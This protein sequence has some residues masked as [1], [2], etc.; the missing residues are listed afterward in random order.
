MKALR[1]HG[2]EDLRLEEVEPPTEELGADEVLLEGTACGIC[3]T[4]MHEYKHGPMM[5]SAEPHPLSGGSLPQI[6]GHEVAG[7][8]IGVGSD[9]GEV[10]IGDR[11][12]VM[13]MTYCG[14]CSHCRVG[15]HQL[16]R[17]LSTFGYRS[18][19]GGFAER[20][21][22]RRDQVALLP[23]GVADAA[24]ALVE[25]AA[26]AVTAAASAEIGEGDVVL[27]TGGGPIGQLS[28]LAAVTRGAATVLVSRQRPSRPGIDQ[29]EGITLTDK[30]SD[31]VLEAVLELTA[32]DGADAV[33]ECSGRGPGLALALRTVKSG[34]T[35]T[36]VGGEAEPLPLDSIELVMRNITLRG[37]MCYPADSWPRIIEMI[38]VGDLPVERTITSLVPLE[39]AI[40][41][42][43]ERLAG[44][45]NDEVK[46]VVA[47]GSDRFARTSDKKGSA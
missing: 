14:E 18:R 45:G 36:Q 43:F 22:V 8:V 3:G 24:G 44:P 26:V 13:P 39:E 21:V 6:I 23:E 12:A 7:R 11:V 5:T 1:F 2:S 38:D 42:G 40:S 10:S 46:V 4:D 28:A 32:G 35:V 37:S 29:V 34:G 19:W 9:V 16:C 15:T 47:T 27:V 31:D 17:Q 20:M 41:D 25:P 33:I 30:G